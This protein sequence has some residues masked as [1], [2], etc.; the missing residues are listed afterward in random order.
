MVTEPI[1][2]PVTSIW[3]LV[4]PPAAEMAQVGGEGSVTLPFPPAWEKV[5]FSPEMA[6]PQ[7]DTVAVQGEERPTSNCIAP[8]ALGG[9]HETEM[10]VVACATV[11]F[12]SPELAELTASPGYVAWMVAAPGEPPITVIEQLSAESVQVVREGNE[13]PPAPPV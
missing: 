4:F 8:P 3:Q 7:P 2:L 1:E 13:T 12:A 10:F 5:S 6:P 9:V 11:T